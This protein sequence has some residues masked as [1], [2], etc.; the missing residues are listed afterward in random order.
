MDV[1]YAA[2]HA[3]AYAEG[4]TRVF[5]NEGGAVIVE[6]EVPRGNCRASRFGRR[7][8]VRIGVRSGAVVG[9]M[10]TDRQT[11]D[12]AMTT[13]TATIDALEILV[14]EQLAGR[15]LDTTVTVDRL[16]EIALGPGAIRC[17]MTSDEHG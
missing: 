13:T 5:P 17:R 2:G 8:P 12:S 9:S 14:R 1:P 11:G 16:F 4:K 6:F 15:K 10:A 3:E 7:I